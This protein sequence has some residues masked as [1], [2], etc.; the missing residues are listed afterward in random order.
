[1][2]LNIGDTIEVTAHETDMFGQ[3][4]AKYHDLVVFVK[5]L[6]KDEKALVTIRALKK[7]FAEATIKK[8]LIQTSTRRTL[9][10]R[11][12]SL[13]LYHLRDEDQNNWQ[14]QITANHFSRKLGYN[15]PIEPIIS[16]QLT[17]NYRNKVVYH[18]LPKPLLT[19]GMYEAE[20]I[21]LTEVHTFI[22]NSHAIQRCVAKLQQQT[23]EI[24]PEIFKHVVLRSNEKEQVL[25]TLVATQKTFTG[26]DLLVEKI[27]TFKEVVGLTLNIKPNE[28]T[29]L[30]NESYLLFGK[31]EIQFDFGRLKLKLSDQSFMQ[32]NRDV[33]LKTY[34]YIRKEIQG[35][36]VIDCYS[37]IGS[38]GFYI[39]DLAKKVIMIENNQ[40]NIE[41]AHENKKYHQGHYEIIKGNAEK[42]LPNLTS[43][44]LVVDPPR[45]GLHDSLLQVL[46]QKTFKK[47]IY[48]SCEL[49]TLTRDLK[50]LQEAYDIEKLVPV[51]MFPQTTSIETL[52]ILKNKNNQ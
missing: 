40:A 52:V 41:A 37:G 45:A 15:G 24:D 38:I 10:S 36:I 9:P 16:S 26:L 11:L 31:N 42:I 33:M 21:Q 43:D 46:N 5:G 7:H 23:V 4:V 17:L 34:D 8:I 49:S 44:I 30:G 6:I 51:R 2:Q 39:G 12:G 3:G 19:L 35:G 25:M 29:I 13:D 48:L 28:K 1:M 20:P 32:V 14:T 22:L 18:V 47:L 27:K 50:V